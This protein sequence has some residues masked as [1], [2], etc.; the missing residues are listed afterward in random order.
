[1]AG[2]RNTSLIWVLG[3]HAVEAVLRTNPE[4]AIELHVV[5]SINSSKQQL[6][7][8]ARDLGI[9]VLEIDKAGLAKRS[10]SHN[11]QGIGLLAKPRREGSDTELK[12]MLEQSLEAQS[13]PL[14]L[15]LDQVQDPHNFG[16]C[17]RTADAAGVTAVIVAKD[18]SSPLTPIV[19]KVASGAAETVAIYR[20]S[21]LARCMDSLKQQ[22]IW[23][24]GTSDKAEKS[25]FQEALTGPL[26]I[27]M[28]AEGKGLRDLT[29]KKCDALVN[30]PMAGLVVSSLNVSVATGVCLYEAVRQ[31]AK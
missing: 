22:G 18:N 10:D 21:N 16:A 25:I 24:I 23:L 14:L 31:R 13:T 7:D 17:L 20:V 15:I 26:G 27:V 12:S 30:L 3:T 8:Q 9:P 19:Q 1:M 11:H 6:V 28:G 4:R 29:E 2:K 5:T